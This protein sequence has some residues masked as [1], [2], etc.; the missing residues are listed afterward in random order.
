MNFNLD[1]IKEAIEDELLYFPT[2]EPLKEVIK[3]NI[4]NED[5]KQIGAAASQ[6]TIKVLI[7]PPSK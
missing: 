5:A 1:D 4:D 6:I 3:Q 2:K 7:E